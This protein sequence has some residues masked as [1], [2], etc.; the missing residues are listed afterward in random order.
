MKR[1]GYL[2]EFLEFWTPR[3]E[4]KKVWFSLFTPQLGDQIPEILG[5]EER[6]R[7]MRI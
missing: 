1:I 6:A 4:I 2:A 3:R 5:S 7:A